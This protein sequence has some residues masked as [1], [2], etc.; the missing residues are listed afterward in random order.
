MGLIRCQRSLWVLRS[1]AGCRFDPP[2]LQTHQMLDGLG[3]R[4]RANAAP[5]DPALG[6]D[7]AAAQHAGNFLVNSSPL[8]W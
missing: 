2:Y 8:P 6:R 7:R 4:E 5:Q 3:D 1:N